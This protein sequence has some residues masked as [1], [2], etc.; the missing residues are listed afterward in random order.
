MKEIREGES[1]R[2]GYGFCWI[3]YNRMTFTVA[4]LPFNFLLRWGRRFYFYLTDTS[5][6]D[7]AILKAMSKKFSEGYEEGQKSGSKQTI[8]EVGEG[9]GGGIK[10]MENLIDKW[11]EE[12]YYFNRD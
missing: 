1:V 9:L 8:I 3:N 11:K 10:Q 4:P 7:D 12:G 6:H 5:I 2:W